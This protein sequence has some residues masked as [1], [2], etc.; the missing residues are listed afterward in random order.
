VRAAPVRGAANCTP[1]FTLDPDTGKKKWKLE[2][3]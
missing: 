3:L 1:P 2:C